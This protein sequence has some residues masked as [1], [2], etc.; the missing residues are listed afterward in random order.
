VN[1][2]YLLVF[3]AIG[4]GISIGWLLR[5]Y[6][7]KL[8]PD[9]IAKLA[10][11]LAIQNQGVRDDAKEQIKAAET[12]CAE[13]KLAVYQDAMYWRDHAQRLAAGSKG[14]AVEIPRP[15]PPAPS[16]NGSDDS[17]LPDQKK[18]YEHLLGKGMAPETAAAVA[19]GETDGFPTDPVFDAMVDSAARQDSGA[20]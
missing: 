10:E 12:R 2:S 18:L 5:S 15:P 16:K 14:P 9:G 19:R 1:E 8:S 4:T 3:L 17:L 11:S 13:Y 7:G 20:V 6:H